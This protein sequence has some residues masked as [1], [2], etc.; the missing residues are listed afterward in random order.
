MMTDDTSLREI[1]EKITVYN[2]GISAEYKFR[3]L[4]FDVYLKKRSQT[5]FV[6][7]NRRG[8]YVVSVREKK[9]CC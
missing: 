7:F 1:H 2:N 8:E 3:H 4:I 9:I 5:Q 6:H